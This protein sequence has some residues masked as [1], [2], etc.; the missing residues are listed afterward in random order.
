MKLLIALLLLF[1]FLGC[2]SASPTDP[3]A[4]GPVVPLV[5]VPVTELNAYVSDVAKSFVSVGVMI[6]EYTAISLDWV[7][8]ATP[9]YWTQQYTLNLIRRVDLLQETV[10][11]IRPGNAE[12]LRIHTEYEEALKDY[13]GAFKMFLDQ[14][15]LPEPVLTEEL[16]YKIAD[17]NVHLIR[18]QVLLSQLAGRDINF[19]RG[20]F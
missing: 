14:T 15:Q 20:P 8:G 1:A 16:A 4:P 6:D 9:R 5:T 10:R 13:N 2:G 7:A 12:L 3:G 11:G 19:L 18:Y 17:G